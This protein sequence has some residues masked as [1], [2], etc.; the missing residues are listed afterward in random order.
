MK[1]TKL[2]GKI[3]LK[4]EYLFIVILLLFFI[5]SL[6]FNF[7]LLEKI[8]DY[9]NLKTYPNTNF[10]YISP[11]IAWIN[12]DD[13]L[14]VQKYYSIEYGNL[15]PRI[16]EFLSNESI[17]GNYG[18]YFEDLNTGAWVGINEKVEFA[19]ASLLKLPV[20]IA[21]LKKLELGEIALE[22][23]VVLDYRDLDA[24][25]GNLWAKGAG[26]EITV[27]DLLI[28]MIN[29]SDNTAL[30]SFYNHEIISADDIYRVQFAM[31][32]VLNSQADI[33]PKQYSNILRTFYYSTYLRR[34]F[35]EL[36]LSIMSKTEYD[37]QLVKYIPENITVA[38]KIGFYYSED[39][40]E[41]H[42][43][44][45]IIYYPNKNYILCVMSSETNRVEADYV[46]SGISKLVYEYVDN[47]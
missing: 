13:F 31:G 5:V 23:K 29:Q 33:S 20:L 17:Q 2:R 21:V 6:I 22:D 45:G 10:E 43:D 15:N 34:P 16:R 24:R 7:V 18:I 44:C 42:H 25:S 14:N 3:F 11:N 32:W 37:S 39:G 9:K 46:I 38:H 30:N 36:G 1:S 41:G 27:K 40:K 26:Y 19:P 47:I 12:L 35:S 4:I 8:S 28:S